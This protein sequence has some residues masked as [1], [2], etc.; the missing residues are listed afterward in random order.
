[1][2]RY[3]LLL[4]CPFPSVRHG[5]TCAA[6]AAGGIDAVESVSKKKAKRDEKD[7]RSVDEMCGES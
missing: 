6:A 1:M 7:L 3:D 5:R 2:E 4:L